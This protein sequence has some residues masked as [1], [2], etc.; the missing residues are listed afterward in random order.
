[1]FNMYDDIGIK[2]QVSNPYNVKKLE[3]IAPTHNRVTDKKEQESKNKQSFADHLNNEAKNTYKK[4]A[5]IHVE[6]E[7]L[8]VSQLM[9]SEIITIQEDQSIYECW[10]LMEESDLKQIPV[11]GIDG[12]IKGLAT[13]KN[14]LNSLVENRNNSEYIMQTQII[15]ITKK[16]IMT[17]E[18]I[19]DIRRVAKVMIKYHLNTIPIVDSEQDKVVGIISRADILKAVATNPHYQLW[20]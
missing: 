18:P 19:S 7:I 13:M 12:K 8:H 6:E 1:M 2:T 14:M 5:N 20:A 17:A 3:A 11:I 15:K 9:H 16:D 4:M 10:Q